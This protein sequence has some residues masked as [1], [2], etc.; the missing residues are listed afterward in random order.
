MN[1]PQY[2]YL[3]IFVLLTQGFQPHEPFSPLEEK[4]VIL[5]GH[6][7][8][9]D[10]MLDWQDLRGD[11]S[12]Y[13]VTFWSERDGWQD[14]GNTQAKHFRDFG[15]KQRFFPTLRYR[16]TATTANGSV[17]YSNEIAV[18]FGDEAE[19]KVYPNPTRGQIFIDHITGPSRI[20][21]FDATG[22]QLW[23]INSTRESMRCDL[24]PFPKGM[25]LLKISFDGKVYSKNVV[26]Q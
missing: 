26:L 1:A 20:Q 19:P 18:A 16:I 3:L 8:G 22:R 7:S 15:A 5:R 2:F 21:L 10:V 13:E 14:L 25:Y 9:E 11:A 4:K 17:R 23:S 12:N 24:S 6:I